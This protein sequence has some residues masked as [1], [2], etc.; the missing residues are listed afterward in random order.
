MQFKT[1]FVMWAPFKTIQQIFSFYF[2]SEKAYKYCP[3]DAKP[4]VLELDK[5]HWAM[6]MAESGKK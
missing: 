6:K 3:G 1:C 4:M 5:K 2:Q